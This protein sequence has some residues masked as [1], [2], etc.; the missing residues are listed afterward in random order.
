VEAC[1]LLLTAVLR[2]LVP[3]SSLCSDFGP[4]S[5]LKWLDSALYDYSHLII[6]L[7][8]LVLNLLIYLMNNLATY[9]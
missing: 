5:G 2:R 3:S 1:S 8:I 9:I 4:G 7:F 6:Y